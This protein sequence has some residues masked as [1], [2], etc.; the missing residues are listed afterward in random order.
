MESYEE[1]VQASTVDQ[2][3]QCY[4]KDKD[5]KISKDAAKLSAVFLQTYIEE[6]IARTIEI[7]KGE[8]DSVVDV[9]HVSSDLVSL[10]LCA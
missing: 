3:L 7:A 4:W 10:V 6:A 1:H 5:T 8:D 2:I 9:N